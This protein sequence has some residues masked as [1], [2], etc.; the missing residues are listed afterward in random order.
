MTELTKG[1]RK[2]P[3]LEPLEDSQLEDLIKRGRRVSLQP[4]EVLFRKGDAGYC[5]Y[6]ILDGRIQIYL[7]TKEGRGAVLRV[8]EPGEFFGEMALLDG[9]ARSA[10]ALALVPC[11]LFVLERAKFL[12]LLTTSPELLTRLFSGLTERL[13]AT[14]E[15]YLQEEL[16]KQTLWAETERERHRSLAEM[17]ARVADEVDMLLEGSGVTHKNVSRAHT[18]IRSFKNLS[19][20]QISDTKESLSLPA[21]VNEVL[22]VFSIQAHEANLEVEFTHSLAQEEQTWTGYRGH[23]SRILLNLL[24]NV[25]RYAYAGGKGGKVEVTLKS[26][27]GAPPGYVLAVRDHGRGI[28]PENLKQIFEPFAAPGRTKDYT[29]LGLVT[30]HNLVTAALHGTVHA[31]SEVGQGTTFTVKFPHVIPETE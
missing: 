7:E 4:G 6:V 26:A 14:D 8:L 3:F 30:V 15:R 9:V 2:V 23:L 13:R 10:N 29:G 31:E 18:L 19:A 27:S 20:G 12:D 17:S 21:L 22:A 24:T 28:S 16:A 1:L 5:M 11:A 25:E